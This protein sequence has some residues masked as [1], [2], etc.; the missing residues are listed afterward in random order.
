MSFIINQVLTLGISSLQ[1]MSQN[2]NLC[3]S[4]EK[5]YL[6]S[7]ICDKIYNCL[8]FFVSINIRKLIWKCVCWLSLYDSR[9]YWCLYYVKMKFRLQ[10]FVLKYLAENRVNFISFIWS[11]LNFNLIFF[12]TTDIENTESRPR[13]MGEN[14][15]D[16]IKKKVYYH[17]NFKSK[18]EPWV[19]AI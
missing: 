2:C 15:N 18:I 14:W 17:E 3:S 7:F 8:W 6:Y 10:T 13:W 1:Y 4:N 12:K 19:K 16:C 9:L 5:K 11:L